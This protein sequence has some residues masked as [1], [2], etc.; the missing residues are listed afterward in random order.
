M[1]RIQIRIPRLSPFLALLA[2]ATICTAVPTSG[3]YLSK[4]PLSIVSNI[5][6]NNKTYT[7]EELA[8]YGFIASNF[9]DKF[10]D[11]ISVGSSIALEEGSWQKKGRY[12]A[13]GRESYYRGTLWM[14]PDRGWFVDPMLLFN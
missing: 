7:Y 11:T 6:C 1:V 12:T 5:T 13:K 14:M 4:E 9:R 10:G 3:D 2:L 8:G